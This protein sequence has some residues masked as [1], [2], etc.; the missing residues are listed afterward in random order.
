MRAL[1]TLLVMLGMGIAA[2]HAQSRYGI[3]HNNA[4]YVMNDIADPPEMSGPFPVAGI[5]SGQR[6]VQF[7]TSPTDGL[8]YALGYDAG[9]TQAQLYRLDIAN[10]EYTGV[11]IGA[12]LRMYLGDGSGVAFDFN[13]SWTNV[14]MISGGNGYHNYLLDADNGNLLDMGSMGGS[15]NVANDIGYPDV[16]F[17]PNPVVTQARILLP[18]PAR[19]TV[20]VDIVDLRGQI[21]HSYSY[22]PGSNQLELDMSTLVTG[23]YN[24]RMI[25]QGKGI[26]SIKVLKE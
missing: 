18:T 26:H 13:P 15:L 3:D 6:I 19:H 25:E 17:Y 20:Y 21:A 23:M 8:L 24:V 4:I 14:L 10:D 1:C 2:S 7:D 11:A 9:R 16:L 22:P 12:P 5:T